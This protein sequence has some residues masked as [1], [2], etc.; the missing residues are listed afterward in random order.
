MLLNLETVV[1]TFCVFVVVVVIYIIYTH[2]YIYIYIYTYIYI[3]AYFHVSHGICLSQ[4]KL[5]RS[6]LTPHR[7]SP[8]SK[9]HATEQPHEGASSGAKA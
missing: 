6:N 5:I 7:R 9:L 4:K 1:L 3:H 8:S 2:V